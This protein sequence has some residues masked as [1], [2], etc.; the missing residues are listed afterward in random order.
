M[1]LLYKGMSADDLRAIASL[2]SSEAWQLMK[3]LIDRRAGVVKAA[4]DAAALNGE[5]TKVLRPLGQMNIL[6]AVGRAPKQALDQLNK[7]EKS[8]GDAQRKP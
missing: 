8:D 1:T 6:E 2:E 7:K 5:P 4:I 3:Q